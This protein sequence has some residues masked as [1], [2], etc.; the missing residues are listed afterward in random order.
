MQLR[1]PEALCIFN[2]HHTGIGHI[3]PHLYDR[4]SHHN[5][6]FTFFEAL[7]IILLVGSLH[8]PMDDT[9]LIVGRRKIAADRLITLFERQ[10]IKFFIL[11]NERI[12]NIHLS[13]NSN[14]LTHKTQH[15]TAMVLR[16][17]YRFYRFAARR[18]LIDDRHIEVAVE[19]HRQCARDRGSRHDENMGR[20]R[21]ALG[22]QFGPLL[23]PK[24]VLFVDDREAQAV[25]RHCRLYERMRT[26]EY[27][28]IT[29]RQPLQ[30]LFAR[31]TLYTAR[32]E[33]HPQTERRCQLT[34]PQKMLLRQNLRRRHQACLKTIV[35]GHEHTHEPDDRLTTAYIPLQQAVHL[36]AAAQI[37]AYFPQHPLLGIGQ[38][39]RQYFMKKTVEILPDLIKCVANNHLPPAAVEL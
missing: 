12:D 3:D 24:P 7:H 21:I 28:D 8:A 35:D 19:G 15:P 1:K 20:I 29:C 36:P 26:N 17:V 2:N 5:M 27:M 14:L 37:A 23:H 34:N 38:R 4:C 9:H 11:L 32:K 31:L 18:Q 6:C 10:Q 30:Y 13:A 22:P 33:S 16:I 25:K 39:E